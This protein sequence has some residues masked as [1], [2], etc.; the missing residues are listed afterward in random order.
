M[1]DMFDVVLFEALDARAK[2][3]RSM[4]IKIK[5]AQQRLLCKFFHQN[6][7]KSI[8]EFRRCML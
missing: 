7:F 2:N 6:A 5:F 8:Y 1:K 4:G 3:K